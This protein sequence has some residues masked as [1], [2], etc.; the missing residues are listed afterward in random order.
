[1]KTLTSEGKHGIQ[2]TAQNQLDDSNFTDDLAL[3]SNTHEQMQIKTANVAAVSASSLFK[4]QTHK[5]P[6]QTKLIL[7][8]NH[9]IR[10]Q[11]ACIKDH[12]KPQPFPDR[13]LYIYVI[14][15][16]TDMRIELTNLRMYV[17][18]YLQRICNE[19]G[20]TLN[21]I[22]DSMDTD[23]EPRNQLMMPMM[24]TTSDDSIDDYE[25]KEYLSRRMKQKNYLN[26]LVSKCFNIF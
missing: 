5:K 19:R 25:L 14:A 7:H 26:C 16:P 18:P 12:P 4:T 11:L 13:Q 21:I 3:L 23:I 8:N 17:W 10:K 20:F 9:S 2:W 22:D 1:M 24:N 6:D 15:D